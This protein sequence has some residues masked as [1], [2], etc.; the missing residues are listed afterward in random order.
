MVSCNFY[1]KVVNL[2]SAGRWTF[3]TFVSS[4]AK[5]GGTHRTHGGDEQAFVEEETHVAKKCLIS[6]TIRET[7]L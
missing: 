1:G 2:P 7:Q 5:G 6:L 4:C 3:P